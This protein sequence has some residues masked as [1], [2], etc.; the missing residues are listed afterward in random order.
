MDKKRKKNF[1]TNI[2]TIKNPDTYTVL[3]NKY[4]SL[5]KYAP[6]DLQSLSFNKKYQ[7]REKAAIAFEKLVNI[8]KKDH[9]FIRP[10]SAYR[11][12]KYQTK[13]YNAYVKKDGQDKADTYSARPGHSEH[14]TGLAVDVWTEGHEN[15][16]EKDAKWL[17]ENANKYGFIIRYT[18]EKQA[19]TGYIAEPWHLRYV[20]QKIA[21]D[22]TNKNLSY[23]EYYELYIK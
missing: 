15:I 19:I 5:G 3:V 10:Y 7:L 4:R 13:V 23:D 18:K 16:L 22:V 8:A 12:F 6:N 11:S 14:Q 21:K 20:G 2:E 1:Y 9:V 17:A